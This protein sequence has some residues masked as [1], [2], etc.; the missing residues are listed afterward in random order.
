MDKNK[1]KSFV[2]FCELQDEYLDDIVTSLSVQHFDK[3]N[4]LFKRGRDVDCSFYLMEGTVDLIDRTYN[5]ESVEAGSERSKCS[6]NPDSPTQTSCLAKSKITVCAIENKVL[7]RVMSWSE[8][9]AA[10]LDDFHDARG[11]QF[12]VEEVS[13]ETA[14]DWMSSLLQSPLFNRIPASQVQTLFL[15]F[16]D[17]AVKAG[18]SVVKEGE[19]GD[20]FYVLASGEARVSN[21]SETVDITLSPGNHF[22]EEAL[23]GNTT[24]NATVTMLTDGMLKRLNHDDFTMLLKEP[25]LQ[26]LDSADSLNALD[27]PYQLIDVKMPIEY[28]ME[29]F[30]G[31]INMP[32][33]KLRSRFAD[34]EKESVYVI[35]GD[36]GSRADIAAH[37]LCQAGYDTL[38]LKNCNA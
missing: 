19:R 22:G 21:Q 27:K 34:L 14:N 33:S 37:L 15:K 8:S 17:F 38:I 32:L 7:D 6:L 28:R 18:Q 10:V 11:G 3:G 9:A 20:Y 4:M 26:Y 30:P 2:P 5:V 35:T 29:H 36:S 16:G 13:E 23:L 24:R 31:S 1:L 25:V 12:H